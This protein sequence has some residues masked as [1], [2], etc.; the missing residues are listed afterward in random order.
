MGVIIAAF[1]TAPSHLQIPKQYLQIVDELLITPT[2]LI[3]R[4]TV[5]ELIAF[6]DLLNGALEADR[7]HMIKLNIDPQLKEQVLKM[8]PAMRS[9]TVS[10]LSD[11]AFAI[12]T[13]IPK[14]R[15]AE[16]LIQLRTLGAT[17]IVVM[18]L[19]AVVL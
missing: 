10:P 7:H 15:T 18:S 8:L 2:M 13:V 16:L 14:S 11:Q 3:A 9:P 4:E 1:K 17:D 5:P 19:N 6:G 12:E